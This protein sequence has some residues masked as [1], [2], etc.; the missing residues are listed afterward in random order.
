MTKVLIVDDNTTILELLTLEFKS[1][2]IQV[3][4]A[5]DGLDALTKLKENEISG[6]LLDLFM[7]NMDGLQFL[8]SLDD[9]IK[10]LPIIVMSGSSNPDIQSAL[11]KKGIDKIF[12]K[13]LSDDDLQRIFSIFK[14][15]Y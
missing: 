14:S 11:H 5:K 4:K 1:E 6:I 3:T 10:S 7:P 2:N 13:P 9:D 8:D 12:I 15:G